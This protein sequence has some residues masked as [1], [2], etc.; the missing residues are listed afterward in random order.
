MGL[1]RETRRG[2]V[3]WQLALILL[4][5]G[6]GA[7]LLVRLVPDPDVGRTAEVSAQ[8]VRVQ[9]APD[10]S[11]TVVYRYLVDGQNFERQHPRN[12]WYRAESTQVKACYNPA[13]PGD[14]ELAPRG[15]RCGVER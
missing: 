11:N 14:S 3:V 7:F 1:A 8:V 5:L 2:L 6:I 4:A 10:G 15:G 13:N 12:Q 9:Q